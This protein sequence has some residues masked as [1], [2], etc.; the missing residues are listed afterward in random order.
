[1][2]K[3]STVILAD[4]VKLL[5]NNETTYG[6]AKH[7]GLS[8]ACIKNWYLRGTVM[9]DETGIRIAEMLDLDPE[10]VLIWLQVERMEKKG[11]DILSQHWRHIAE[12]IAA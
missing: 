1:M 8:R 5:I 12:Q 11:N 10:T 4:R 6:L 3:L 7:L 9:D 2:E